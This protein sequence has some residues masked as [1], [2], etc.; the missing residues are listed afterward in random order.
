[1]NKS[2]GG[3]KNPLYPIWISMKARCNNLNHAAY[4]S[5]GGR[6]IKVCTE[7]ANSFPNFLKDMGDK[8]TQKHSID[9]IN[10]DMGYLPDNCRWAT[11]TEQSRNRR[12]SRFITNSQT[13]E[14]LTIA[15]W[16]LRL[17]GGATLVYLR[18]ARGW[19][20]QRAI[21]TPCRAYAGRQ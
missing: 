14:T 5:Y 8:P 15:E 10:N 12:N 18:L 11:M 9:R 3:Y 21:S 4:P 13:G 1:M 6:G 7:W 16:C 17:K 20:E 19:S 2:H